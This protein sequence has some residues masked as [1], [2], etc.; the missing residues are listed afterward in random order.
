ML[1]RSR[2]SE[3]PAD[4]PATNAV[5]ANAILT[6][7][8]ALT[9]RLPSEV[10]RAQSANQQK[11][12]EI[13]LKLDVSA[14]HIDMLKCHPLFRN[15]G[16]SGKRELISVYLD[17]KGRD[18]RR[19]GLSFRLRRKDGQL[20]Q[21]IKGPY[22]G[23][24]GRTERETPFNFDGDGQPGSADAFL[25]RLG[26]RRLPTALKPIFKTRIEREIYQLGDIEVC[27]DKGEIIA[28][29]RSAPVAEIELELKS[30]DRSELFALARQISAI[31][32]AEISV[33]SKSER[34]YE[35]IDGVKNR[36]VMAQDPGLLPS[37]TIT[38][39]FQIICNEC[40]HQLI[41][42]KSG[43]RAHVSEALHQARV[44]L[45]R[46]D[47]AIKLFGKILNEQKATKVGGE[48]KWIGDELAGAR[49]L[50]VFITDILLPLRTKHPKES[51]VV[52][53]DR[54]CILQREAAYA[55]ANAA[56]ASQRFRTFLIDVAEW[57]E[58]GSQQQKAGLRLKG[59]PSAKD[60]VSRTL[61]KIWS[62][63]TPGR[64]IDELDLRRLHKLRLRAKRM[65]YTIELTR[66]L[67]EA[68]PRRVERLL[69][70][71]GKLQSALGQLNDLASARTIL[72]RIAVEAKAGPKNVEAR[73][74][75]GPVTKI[76]A[77][78]ESK[79]SK[80]LKKAAKAFEKLEDIKPFWI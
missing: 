18:F 12:L 39:A 9:Y 3:S 58:T 26:D 37:A 80:Q 53:V 2:T 14:K 79:K 62:K 66:G 36:A 63:M 16:S 50:D 47:A 69:K 76:A 52:K 8:G 29:R 57:I 43:V 4:C 38:E 34:G 42:N 6:K 48:L 56:L 71:L 46:F 35:L 44:A 68:N 64:H 73:V 28:G 13:E 27:L 17:T 75:S 45:R 49:E 22:R 41:S 15:C 20:L 23:I 11:P 77:N 78:H 55:R 32:P 70:Q 54:A 59:E 31:V 61:S 40:L 5:G 67:H 74:T 19:R 30:G 25:K 1:K 24:L 7:E 10:A 65:R 33:K 72:H 21:A 60:R 51:I